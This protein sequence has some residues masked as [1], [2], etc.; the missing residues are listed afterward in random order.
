MRS[1][2]KAAR[3]GL[4]SG[5]VI[6]KVGKTTIR[7]LKDFEKA[8]SAKDGPIALTVE[9]DGTTLFLAVR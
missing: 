9:R 2:S 7:T 5:D 4:V 6:R 8:I 3:A 1:G